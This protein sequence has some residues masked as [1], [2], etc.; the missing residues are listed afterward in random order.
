MLVVAL[1]WL[2]LVAIPPLSH[3]SFDLGTWL[4]PIRVPDEA[5]IVTM[6][7]DS[8]RALNQRPEERWSRALHAE[9]LTRLSPARP[10]AVVFDSTFDAAGVQGAAADA[11]LVEAARQSERVVVAALAT[12]ARHAD[13]R[14]ALAQVVPP[15]ESL[16]AVTGWGAA[17]YPAS[18]VVRESVREVQG[19]PSLARAVYQ[20]LTGQDI[21]ATRGRWIR[22]YG[23]PGTLRR[24]P[25][26]AVLRGEVP[27]E[28][29]A[30]KLV[31]IGADY[32][33][34]YPAGG[35]SAENPGT[36]TLA[37]PY[38]LLT[39][40]RSAGVEVV[41]TEALNLLRDEDLKRL[42]AWLEALL[43]GVAGVA[44]VGTFRRIPRPLALAALFLAILAVA[45][46]GL[47]GMGWA[48]TWF[49]WTLVSAL[50][51]PA[52]WFW[53]RSSTRATT[54]APAERIVPT[55]VTAPVE[56]EIPRIPDF[57]LMRCIG[58][59][60]Y[61]EVWLAQDLIQTWRVVKVVR[62]TSFADARPYEREFEGMRRCAPLSL[63]HPNL[64]RIYHVGRDAADHSFH[65]VM[66]PADAMDGTRVSAP[67]SYQPRTLDSELRRRG[68]LPVAEVARLG[69]AL[70]RGLQYLH[71][72]GLVHRDLKPANILFVG[73]IPKLADV[74]LVTHLE[75][76]RSAVSHVGTPGYLAPEGPGSVA[77]DI[78]A[79]GKVLYVAGSGRVCAEF[80]KLPADL[81]TR[82][83]LPAF[84][85]LNAL[86]LRACEFEPG[87]R[88][89]SMAEF[90]QALEPLAAEPL[91]PSTSAP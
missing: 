86:L 10:R 20:R 44:A 83:D 6:D 24:V 48:R 36:D 42:P 41:A 62:R 88:F 90:L 89:A 66:E 27:L 12:P 19:Q 70:A 50:Q 37:T 82:P 21:T 15:F 28:R 8:F 69:I 56:P 31:F 58:R 65:Y 59:G 3:L 29:F 57:T 7:L 46:A 33:G 55:A 84:R 18:G 64:V 2:G 52:A 49:P 30:D 47:A 80:P 4:R 60:A 40:R 32:A 72:H 11:A 9:L 68:A 43:L 71:E 87:R 34:P 67:E 53:T 91:A 39:R 77:A 74:G 51:L 22:Y 85:A 23:P 54:D 35:W 25:Y 1:G 5:V 26:A 63:D 73:G 38:T 45:A 14:V 79:L 81:A 76:E 17:F 78:Y 75:A 13:D 16:R 61:G